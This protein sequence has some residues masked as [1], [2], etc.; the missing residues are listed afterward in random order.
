MLVENLMDGYYSISNPEDPEPSLV[1]L[2]TNPDTHERGFGFNVR[3]GGGFL[4]VCDLRED[5]T[6]TRVQIVETR[7]E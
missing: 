4:P 6:V 7:H 3:D 2:Y 5:T 1:Y